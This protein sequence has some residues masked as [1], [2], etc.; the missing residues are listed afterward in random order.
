MK[1][2]AVL[3]L[4]T[5]AILLIFACIACA[6]TYSEDEYCDAIWKAEGGEQA[7]YYYGIK[8]VN[9]ITG[10]GDYYDKQ[11]ARRI[12]KNTVRNNKR[13]FREYGHRTHKTFLDFLGSRYAPTKGLQAWEVT[14]N[15][16]WKRNILYFLT[17]GE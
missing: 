11:E 9:Y 4:L 3:T 8:S 6:N 13:R 7:A 1:E 17:K 2:Y 10:K 5:T 15:K 16:N 14:L 12:C